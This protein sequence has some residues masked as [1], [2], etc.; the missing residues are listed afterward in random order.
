MDTRLERPERSRLRG[1]GC[2]LA[3]G[4]LLVGVVGALQQNG[5]LVETWAY[6]GGVPDAI[7][8]DNYPQ[9]GSSVWLPVVLLRVVVYAGTFLMGAFLANRLLRIRLALLAFVSSI[10]AGLIFVLILVAIDFSVFSGMSGDSYIRG[11]CP[12]GYLPWWPL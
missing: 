11:K 2:L 12:G 3:L 5:M 7:A 9:G 8:V 6:C 4:A 1:R 10:V